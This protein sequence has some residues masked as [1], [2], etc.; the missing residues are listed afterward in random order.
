VRKGKT[1]V[2]FIYCTCTTIYYCF[3]ILLDLLASP[4][5]KGTT[6]QKSHSIGGEDS[7]LGSFFFSFLFLFYI[8]S[9]REKLQSFCSWSIWIQRSSPLIITINPPISYHCNGHR[10]RHSR[11]LLHTVPHQTA[12]HHR[13][14][15]TLC[16]INHPLSCVRHPSSATPT[17]QPPPHCNHRK[18]QHTNHEPREISIHTYNKHFRP[19]PSKYQ[20]NSSTTFY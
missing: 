8:Q 1:I 13:R 18:H 20:L 15:L 12:L 16:T 7:Q 3:S 14:L 4:G 11:Q 2:G 19:P 9:D 5:K 17:T 6:F 10:H